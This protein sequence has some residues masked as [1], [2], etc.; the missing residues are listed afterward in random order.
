MKNF[1]TYNSP[2]K[3]ELLYRGDYRR[4]VSGESPDVYNNDNV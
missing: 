1:Q 3:A 2:N 4:N